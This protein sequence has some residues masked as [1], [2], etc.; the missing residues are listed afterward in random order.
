MNGQLDP[1]LS[2]AQDLKAKTAQS[3]LR[4]KIVAICESMLAEEM[5]I[6]AGSRRLTALALKLCGGHDEDF[7]TFLLIESDTDHL[8]V[9]RE[10]L[11]WSDDALRRKDSE[12]AECETFYRN[13]A[14]AAC[15]KLIERF[16]IRDDTQQ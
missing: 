15:R 8:P 6:I 3:F 13:D 4:G 10:R 9:D 5:G 14:F 11:N 1:F 12:I 2:A 16:V 7:E